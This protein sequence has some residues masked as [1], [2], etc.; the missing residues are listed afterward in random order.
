MSD[1]RTE[2]ALVH[3]YPVLA[4]FPTPKASATKAG[5]V[6][7][8]DRGQDRYQR[9]VTAWMAVGDREWIWGHYFEKFDDA[10]EDYGAR[11]LRGY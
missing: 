9:Y 11:C 5:H 10:Y 8:V 7:M 2:P 4:A 6:I 1:T 3:G